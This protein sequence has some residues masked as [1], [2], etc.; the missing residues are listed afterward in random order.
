MFNK[1]EESGDKSV[2]QKNPD[3]NPERVWWSPSTLTELESICREEHQNILNS[4]CEG[5]RVQLL[6]SCFNT[7]LKTF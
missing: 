2:K 1:T 4:S 3:M 7:R 5:G 6:Q